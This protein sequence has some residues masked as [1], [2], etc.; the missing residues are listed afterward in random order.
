MYFPFQVIS[1][2]VRGLVHS[3]PGDARFLPLRVLIWV[4]L[5]L[6]AD[7]HPASA[8]LTPS[9]VPQAGLSIDDLLEYIRTQL[10]LYRRR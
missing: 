9:C 6:P 10:Y 8:L 1:W 5:V 7:A 4:G 2:T 3:D